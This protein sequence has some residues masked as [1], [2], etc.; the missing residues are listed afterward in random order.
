MSLQ[1]YWTVV[2][3]VGIALTIPFWLWLWITRPKKRP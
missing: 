1:T 2:P 3:L